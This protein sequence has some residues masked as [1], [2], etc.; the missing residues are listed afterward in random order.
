[1]WDD[2]ELRKQ[3]L[4][5]ILKYE[6]NEAQNNIPSI[7]RSIIDRIN[8]WTFIVSKDGPSRDA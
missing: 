2:F 4:V 3:F 8:R 5:H 1:M 6:E 7:E